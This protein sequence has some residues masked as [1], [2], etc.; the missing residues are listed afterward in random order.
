LNFKNLILAFLILYILLLIV[1]TVGYIDLRA[2]KT[3]NPN[4]FIQEDNQKMKDG[5]KAWIKEMHQTEPGVDYRILDAETRNSK[6]LAR[7][8]MVNRILASGKDPNKIQSL[9]L[10]NGR[11]EGEWIEKGSSNQ[12]GRIRNMDV[13]F[14]RDLLYV[15][16]DGGNIFRGT[17][18]GTDWQCLNN[19]RRIND[20]KGVHLVT[21]P[22]GGKRIVVA[23][24]DSRDGPSRVSYSDD[25]GITWGVY[26][27]VENR[28]L[29]KSVVAFKQNGD[30]VIFVMAEHRNTN[31]KKW[32]ASLYISLD[33]GTTFEVLREFD[34]PINQCDLAIPS[35]NKEQAYMLCRDSAFV[36]NTDKSIKL[37]SVI[38]YGY[39]DFGINKVNLAAQKYESGLY[40]FAA[41]NGGGTT[42]FLTGEE[43]DDW[44]ESGHA[45]VNPFMNFESFAVSAKDREIMYIGSVEVFKTTNAW[46]WEKVSDWW[47]YNSNPQFSLHADIPAIKVFI[48]PDTGEETTYVCTDGG[49]FRSYDNLNT[50]INLSY[51]GLNTSQYYGCYTCRY[52]TDKVF[53]GAQDQGFQVCLSDSGGTLDFDQILS[54]DYS[55]LVSSDGGKNLWTVYP[56]FAM[57]YLN[58][59]DGSQKNFRWNFHGQY[60]QRVWLPPV[61]AN[62]KNSTQ[63]FLP[64]GNDENIPVIWK[65]KYTADGL[66][67]TEMPYDFPAAVT[68]IAQSPLDKDIMYSCTKGGLFFF[69]E[70]TG[71]NW[72]QQPKTDVPGSHHLY[73]TCLIASKKTLG[74]VLV[75]GNGYAGTPVLISEDH[76]L[77]FALL[78]EGLPNTMVYEIA[79]SDDE[80]YV[81][82]A[83]A[84]GPYV[85]S[86]AEEQW[87]DMSG[88]SAPDQ[89]YWSV[90]YI[91]SM[92]TARFTTYG[93][94]IWD[95]KMSKILDVVEQ[96][97]TK[98]LVKNI[99]LTASP[100]PVAANTV[101]SFN[102]PE[103]A[104][105]AVRVYDMNGK[106][107]SE[108]FNGRFEQGTVNLNWNPDRAGVDLPAGTYLCVLSCFSNSSYV[109]LIVE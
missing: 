41:L 5:R 37:L 19:G 103:A 17:I 90:E 44:D 87:F 48:D 39:E 59:A 109:K 79:F 3:V 1:L 91:H 43:G 81:F 83:T 52:E 73:G 11:I 100:N 78:N 69:S 89:R 66:T 84:V 88:I 10:A 2:E 12:A 68:S 32:F 16:S 77:N 61:T 26:Q 104:D 18:E 15:G 96:A 14:D 60:A 30:A 72:T 23:S 98:S 57:H 49:V 21:F 45:K 46:E 55:H 105:G 82:A 33:F 93:R 74:R 22:T 27:E 86:F 75:S 80:E 95:F 7:E 58:L 64:C 102:M 47:A 67:A 6:Q 99:E 85:Y 97:K 20:I 34:I 76:G 31:L 92:K 25:E 24:L 50:V 107:V 65:L 106:I 38:D 108:L 101:I 36:I 53:A 62:L 8:K 9:T 4:E 56:G 51:N 29:R 42:Y 63:A 71:L 35:G 70:D 94:G 54:G 13:D 40:L 28:N